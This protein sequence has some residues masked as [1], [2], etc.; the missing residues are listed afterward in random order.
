[1]TPTDISMSPRTCRYAESTLILRPGSSAWLWLW[2]FLGAPSFKR[3]SLTVG[4]LIFFAY[5]GVPSTCLGISWIVTGSSWCKIFIWIRLKISPIIETGSMM[6]EFTIGGR[7]NLLVASPS[8]KIVIIQMLDKETTVPIIS[9]LWKPKECFES[10]FFYAMFNAAID[11]AKPIRSEARWA[12]SVRIA[13]EP[14]IY[15]PISYATMK[16]KDTK[17]AR[18]NCFCAPVFAFFISSSLFYKFKGVLAGIGVPNISN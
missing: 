10:A 2:L 4:S 17:E 7:K 8:K 12:E 16:N 13:T 9:A 15:P 14:A 11:I 1:M 3:D 6:F 18:Y 5:E